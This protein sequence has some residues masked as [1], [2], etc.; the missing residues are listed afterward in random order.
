MDRRG[1][2]SLIRMNSSSLP[3][4]QSLKKKDSLLFAPLS[5]VGAV[6]FDKD[7]V[8]IDIGRANYTKKENLALGKEDEDLN[9]SDSEDEREYNADEP[10]GLLKSLQDIKSGVDEK[11]EQ[12][13]LRIFKGSKA[14]RAGSDDSSDDEESDANEGMKD[15]K[16]NFDVEKLTRPFRPRSSGSGS[17]S[18]NG[19]DDDEEDSILSDNSS[20]SDDDDDSNSSD[21]E[22]IDFNDSSS[23]NDAVSSWKNN[24]AERAAQSFVGRESS[25]VNL[26]ELIYGSARNAMVVSDDVGGKK[27]LDEGDSD[28]SDDEFFKIRRNGGA[29]S[30]IDS[31]PEDTLLETSMLGEED[32]S[33]V[34][35]EGDD[36]FDISPWLEEGEDCLIES[37]RDKFVTGKWENSGT[38]PDEVYGDFEDFE[39]GEKFGSQPEARSTVIMRTKNVL[40]P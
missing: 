30:S 3:L 8:Y 34:F 27:S 25:T 37:I 29:K 4:K 9:D 21:D 32:S 20:G 19:S 1:T 12:S 23:R 2:L 14:V 36:S 31:N 28:D 5:N 6:S 35:F 16:S 33:R 15:G 17:E 39:T 38:E 13:T 22:S 11:M 24:L 26:Q 7:A 10:A 18:E 40:Q